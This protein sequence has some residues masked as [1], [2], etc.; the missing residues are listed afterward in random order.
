V[1][2]TLN[3]A[4]GSITS[5]AFSSGP[6]SDLWMAYPL[7]GVSGEVY[8]VFIS[9]SWIQSETSN[10]QLEVDGGVVWVVRPSGGT[11]A[12]LGFVVPLSPGS[13]SIRLVSADSRNNQLMSVYAIANKR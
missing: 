8:S 12:S 11:V 7:T 3:V 4:G 9:C 13:H 6:T 2:N 1:I 10:I 5:P